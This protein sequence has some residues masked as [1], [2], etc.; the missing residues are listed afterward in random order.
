MVKIIALTKTSN[1]RHAQESQ[2]HR[3]P[4]HGI[5]RS[6]GRLLPKSCCSRSS[7]CHGGPGRCPSGPCSRFHGGEHRGGSRCHARAVLHE[8]RGLCLDSGGVGTALDDEAAEDAAVIG[9]DVLRRPQAPVIDGCAQ[10]IHCAYNRARVEGVVGLRQDHRRNAFLQTRKHAAGRGQVLHVHRAQKCRCLRRAR[11]GHKVVTS[12]GASFPLEVVA[13]QHSAGRHLALVARYGACV[14]GTICR[15]APVSHEDLVLQVLEQ[16]QSKLVWLVREDRHE[17]TVSGAGG[18]HS[19]Q[20]HQDGNQLHGLHG[21][22]TFWY[23]SL[24]C[25]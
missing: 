16:Q 4:C 8:G 3:H 11:V 23:A 5:H 6:T 17:G 9:P 14:Q 7:G 21:H 22:F 18:L 25:P 24:L 15:Q 20:A 10:L 12:D 19:S 2:E 1:S 13:L